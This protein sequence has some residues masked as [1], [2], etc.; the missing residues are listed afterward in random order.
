MR[1]DRFHQT[2][3]GQVS[4]RAALAHTLP[5]LLQQQRSHQTLD[6]RTPAANVM[7]R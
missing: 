6:E 5:V 2:M 1:I 3:D 4:Q 7:K